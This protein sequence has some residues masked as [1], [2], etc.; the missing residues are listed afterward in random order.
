MTR[1]TM[2]DDGHDK[3][4][5]DGGGGDDDRDDVMIMIKMRYLT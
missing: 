2:N 3:H 1:M 4:D 5:D